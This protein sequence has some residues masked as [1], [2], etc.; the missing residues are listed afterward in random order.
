M[1]PPLQLQP[2][3]QQ[4]RLSWQRQQ[5]QQAPQTPPFLP[6]LLQPQMEWPHCLEAL[7]VAEGLEMVHRISFQADLEQQDKVIV[8]DK[9]I[10]A[11]LL[12]QAEVEAAALVVLAPAKHRLLERPA[13]EAVA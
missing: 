4:Q 10:Q 11:V 2:Q 9:D 13:M 6:A 3:Q 1:L 12:I 5:A 7:E 8:E